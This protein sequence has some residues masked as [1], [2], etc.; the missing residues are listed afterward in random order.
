MQRTERHGHVHKHAGSASLS[1]QA[2]GRPRYPSSA[3]PSC[4]QRF[5][6][7]TLQTSLTACGTLAEGEEVNGEADLWTSCSCMLSFQIGKICLQ[8]INPCNECWSCI[9]SQA[10]VWF[11]TCWQHSSYKSSHIIC[12]LS[13]QVGLCPQPLSCMP[14]RL[15]LLRIVCSHESQSASTSVLKDITAEK[16]TSAGGRQSFDFSIVRDCR[17]THYNPNVFAAPCVVHATVFASTHSP[18]RSGN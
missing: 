1:W 9:W 15:C 10:S 7:L 11:L 8:I 16:K 2:V 6:K 17:A 5:A 18:E 3:S 14:S 13:L 12:S 4:V